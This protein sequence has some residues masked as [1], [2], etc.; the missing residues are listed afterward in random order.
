MFVILRLEISRS[1]HEQYSEI[2]EWL[3]DAP[4][5]GVSGNILSRHFL[6]LSRLER[7]R[8]NVLFDHGAVIDTW[9]L[10]FQSAKEKQ[11]GMMRANAATSS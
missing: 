10:N 2:S 3:V 1:R 5:C 4:S 8:T 9:T 7:E 6:I 11:I